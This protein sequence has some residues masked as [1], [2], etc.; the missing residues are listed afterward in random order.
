MAAA[1]GVLLS[2]GLLVCCFNSCHSCYSI[3]KCRTAPGQPQ[4][5]T[6]H[7]LRLRRRY[8]ASLRTAQ[9]IEGKGLGQGVE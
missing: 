8:Y 1:V 7:Q 3:V 5:V 2:L 9:V 6:S 4:Q